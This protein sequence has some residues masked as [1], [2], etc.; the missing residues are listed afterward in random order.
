MSLAA[1]PLLHRA[2]FILC[3]NGHSAR[4][5]VCGSSASFG[6][7][8]GR[9]FFE[10]GAGSP[11]LWASCYLHRCRR[12]RD[13]TPSRGLAQ[14]RCLPAIAGIILS[15]IERDGRRRTEGPNRQ[16]GHAVACDPDVFMPS[17]PHVE[18]GRGRETPLARQDRRKAGVGS[19]DAPC[20][21]LRPCLWGVAYSGH[22]A[23]PRIVYRDTGASTSSLPPCAIT[24]SRSRQV[25]CRTG[26]GLPGQIEG[27][28][29][30]DH[31]L[32]RIPYRLEDRHLLV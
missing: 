18:G 23:Q 16:L 4:V 5:A 12:S 6:V 28:P 14:L 27:P 8:A 26:A 10:F 25:D 32:D 15:A 19:V 30:H 11:G 29:R 17:P 20:P 21:R 2:R 9:L 24:P 7:A 3:K 13:R 31:I 1:A 22:N